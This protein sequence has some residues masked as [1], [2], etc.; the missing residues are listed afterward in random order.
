MEGQWNNLRICHNSNTS[1]RQISAAHWNLHI[2]DQ[3]LTFLRIWL[4]VIP[5]YFLQDSLYWLYFCPLT[6]L[7]SRE[8]RINLLWRYT[9][10]HHQNLLLWHWWFIKKNVTVYKHNRFSRSLVIWRFVATSTDSHLVEIIYNKLQSI[11][12]RWS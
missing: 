3:D 12:P 6:V 10:P 11:I 1:H 9:Y 4:D 2:Y 5:I 7:P 8:S